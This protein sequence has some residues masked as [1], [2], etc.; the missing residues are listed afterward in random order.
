MKNARILQETQISILLAENKVEEFKLIPEEEGIS[1]KSGV[2]PSP[3]D[4]YQWEVSFTDLIIS[5]TEQLE[6]KAGFLTVMWSRGNVKFIIP[7]LEKENE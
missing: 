4:N 3:Y 1:E 6:Y 5:E 2:F 7:V